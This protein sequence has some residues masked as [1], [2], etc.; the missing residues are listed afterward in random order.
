MFLEITGFRAIGSD[1]KSIKFELDVPS[2]YEPTVLDILDWKSLVAE[3]GGEL[4]LTRE[5]I[6]KISSAINEILP[7]DLELYIGV[8][9]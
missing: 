5:Q 7:I 6:L 4:Q 1:D 2:E 9:I 8:R 3:C